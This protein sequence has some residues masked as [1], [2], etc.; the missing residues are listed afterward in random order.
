MISETR[1]PGYR[2]IV[3]GRLVHNCGYGGGVGRA[4]GDG[5][6]SS[7]VC[8]NAELP[9]LIEQ[10]RAANPN[11]VKLWR[12]CRRR[13]EDLCQAAHRHDRHTA[14]VLSTTAESFLSSFPPTESW[15]M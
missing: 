2:F 7:W 10:W 5:S 1:G 12:A 9:G 8:R 3:S 13:R 4:E 15:P 6:Q 14:S 11:I